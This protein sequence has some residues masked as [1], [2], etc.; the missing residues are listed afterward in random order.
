MSL[1]LNKL[2]GQVEKMG[3]TMAKR[4][5]DFQS[6]GE[7]ARELLMRQPIVTPE[8]ERK[9][10]TARETDEWRRGALPLGPRLDERRTPAVLPEHAS[11]IA[12]D[13]S[14]IYPDRHGIAP[15]YLLNTGSIVFRKGSGQAP[16]VNSAPEIHFED[17]DL[18]DDA[19]ELR[20]VEY[21]N[22]QRNRREIETLAD[23]AERERAA[24][25]GDTSIPIV[26]LVDGPLL[27]W[28][29][30]SPDNRQELQRE[31]E[32][33]VEQMARLKRARA[34]PAGYVDRPGSA[35]V[36]RILELLDLPLEQISRETL[37][38]GRFRQLTDRVLFE[39]LAPNE[40]T[41]LFSPNSDTND[42]YAHISDGDRIAFAY[43]N[44]ARRPGPKESVIVRVELPG[45]V[46]TDPALL[47]AAQAVIY[48]NC[49]PRPFPYVLARAHELAVVTSAE[50]A[51]FEMMLEQA[52]LRNG[53]T[54]AV[55]EKAGL[56]ELTGAGGGR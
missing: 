10:A 1:E 5:D 40:R 29:R 47:D 6:R 28:V 16:L 14:Q 51:G 24:Y 48:D 32:F 15:Y 3:Q 7:Q 18:Y 44:V 26:A 55:S 17:D 21:I 34:I 9:I 35:Y 8:L 52:M 50:R 11:L 30:S 42:R 38:E 36:L 39:E 54:P 4:R 41:G 33:F 13:G 49:V 2:T 37:R 43:V 19:D 45:W 46:A 23:L 20:S 25:G 56:K 12:A 31:L 22:A 27:P 53:L